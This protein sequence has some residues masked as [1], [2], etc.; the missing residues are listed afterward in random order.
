MRGIFVT[1]TDTGVGK[2]VL[3]AAICAALA[4][5]GEKVAAFK[6]VVTGTDEEPDE[7]PRDHELLAQVATIRQKPSD[8]APLSFGPA[9]S[10]HL[11]AEMA[12]DTIEPHELAAA[13][14]GAGDEADALVCEGVGGLLV[15]LTPGYLIRDLALDLQLPLLVAARPGLGTINHTLLTLEAARAA[16]LQVAAVVLTPWPENPTGMERSNRATIESLGQVPTWTLPPTTPATLTHVGNAL[17][18][19]EFLP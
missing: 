12:G 13:A 15:P 5:R 19:E 10:P 11:A 2:T 4:A 3:A 6:P 9:V 17:P 16:G 14:R 7:W 8:V 18:L 1:A